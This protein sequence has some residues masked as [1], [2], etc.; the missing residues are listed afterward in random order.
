MGRGNAALRAIGKGLQ[1]GFKVWRDID[2]RQRLNREMDVRERAAEAAAQAAQ[3]RIEPDEIRILQRLN[4]PLTL[5]NVRKIKFQKD[6][7]GGGKS[8][9][10]SSTGPVSANGEDLSGLPKSYITKQKN[11]QMFKKKIQ[12][13]YDAGGM[14]SQDL[15]DAAEAAG[16]G[17][18]E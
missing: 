3:E 7:G 4:M 5:E 15:L 12:A 16:V 13:I 10:K 8:G 1:G 6:G 14:P 9:V 17:Q 2:E 11:K 18:E